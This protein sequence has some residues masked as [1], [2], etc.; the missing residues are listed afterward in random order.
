MRSLEE[1]FLQ[2]KDKAQ[3]V[4][5]EVNKGKTKYM[6]MSPRGVREQGAIRIGNDM[7]EKVKSFTYLGTEINSSNRISIEIKRRIMLG[8][9]AYFANSKLLKSKLLTR[10]TKM[11]IYNTLIRPVVTY[12]CETWTML[13]E[14]SKALMVFERKIVR[15]IYGPVYENGAWRLRKNREIETILQGKN[16]LRFI[17]ARRIS[18][19]GHVER[20]TENRMQKVMLNESLDAARRRGRPRVRWKQDVE[21]DLRA[22]G[23][24]GWRRKAE[25]RDGWRMIVEE[26]KA[27]IG[28]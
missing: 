23:V 20:M 18:W 16:I 11:R 3:F 2:V 17:K 19:L 24:R 27:H 12:G 9:R 1:V 15:R 8:N 14:D 25:D 7:F 26:A 4:G 5:L 28:L 10:N 21:K 22:M 6:E 13:Q